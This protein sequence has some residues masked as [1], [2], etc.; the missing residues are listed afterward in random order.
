MTVYN[1]EV[2][3]KYVT[4]TKSESPDSELGRISIDECFA[5]KTENGEMVAIEAR[6]NQEKSSVYS[7]ENLNQQSVPQVKN[8]V[9]ASDNKK[10]IDMYN[11]GLL[12]IQKKT[13]KKSINYITDFL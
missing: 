6:G 8:S 10:I 1:I 3:S 9:A 2:G 12:N 5:I 7:N 11:S 13:R 4:F